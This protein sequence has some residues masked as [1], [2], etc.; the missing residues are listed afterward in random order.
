MTRGGKQSGGETQNDRED[1][2]NGR[3]GNVRRAVVGG[4]KKKRE[5]MRI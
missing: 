4:K 3:G 1:L 2:G 5:L